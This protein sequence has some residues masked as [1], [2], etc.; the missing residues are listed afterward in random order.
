MKVCRQVRH[1]GRKPSEFPPPGKPGA[2]RRRALERRQVEPDQRARQ[3][4]TVSRGR[5]ARRAA[6]DSSTGSRSTHK[7]STS[8]TCPGYGY[9]EV[10]QGRARAWR[11]LIEAY[12]DE[13]AVARRRAAADRHPPRRPGRGARLHPVARGA[14]D[15]RSSSR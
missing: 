15:S 5:R 1:L 2:R 14:R 10:K 4:R 3:A 9:A 11:P 6:R 12:L 13:R 8:S 7:R